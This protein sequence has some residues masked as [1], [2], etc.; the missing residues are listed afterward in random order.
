LLVGGGAGLLKGNRHIQ[1]AP[2]TPFANLLLDLTQKFG[3]E[4]GKYGTLSTGRFEV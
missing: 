1:A 4:T 2:Q 3:G